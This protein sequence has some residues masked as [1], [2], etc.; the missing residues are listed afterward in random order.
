[1]ENPADTRQRVYLEARRRYFID[2]VNT[3]REQALELWRQARAA[4]AAGDTSYRLDHLAMEA[5]EA[6]HR[7]NRALLAIEDEI[8]EGDDEE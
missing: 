7:C 6:C 1:M 8:G 4:V 5:E 2:Q 3:L